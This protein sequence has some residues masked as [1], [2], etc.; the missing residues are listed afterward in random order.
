LNLIDCL[1]MINQ[2]DILSGKNIELLLSQIDDKNK[3]F[4][5]LNEVRELIPEDKR[6]EADEIFQNIDVPEQTKS[7]ET[8]KLMSSLNDFRCGTIESLTYKIQWQQLDTILA[9]RD[10]LVDALPKSF[11]PELAECMRAMPIN[12][13]VLFGHMPEVK[14]RADEQT[15]LKSSV[16]AA[17]SLGNMSRGGTKLPHANKQGGQKHT[18]K[19]ST[20]PRTTQP[21]EKSWNKERETTFPVPAGRGSGGY[22][23]NSSS[24]RGREKPAKRKNFSYSRQ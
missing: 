8:F 9:R 17:A 2:F 12:K 16:S 3:L 11:P 21:K 13:E 23:N 14:K 18:P 19:T 5:A 15:N 10:A 20:T 4:R 24:H 7:E 22:N 1:N 6:K